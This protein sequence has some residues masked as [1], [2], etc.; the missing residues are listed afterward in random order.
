VQLVLAGHDHDYQ[1]S[2]PIGAVTYVVSGGAAKLRPANRAEFTE[3]AWS[4]HHFVDL[5]I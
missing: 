3:V 4:T 1:R 2:E 5:L